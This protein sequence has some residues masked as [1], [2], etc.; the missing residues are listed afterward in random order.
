MR[1][2]CMS[3]HDKPRDYFW[4]GIATALGIMGA[5]YFFEQADTLADLYVQYPEGSEE[6]LALLT[7]TVLTNAL[8]V[9]YLLLAVYG[10]RR[11]IR[12]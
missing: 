6:A 4:G 1:K 9:V 11:M 7:G 2:I 8:A 12:E 5:P 3:S 10:G